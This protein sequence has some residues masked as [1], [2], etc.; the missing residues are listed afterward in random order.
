MPDIPDIVD[1][2][3]N[4]VKSFL[5]E[6]RTMI[7]GELVS[8]DSSNEIAQVKPS[9]VD[10]G[11]RGISVLVGVHLLFP[12][13]YW[14]PSADTPGIILFS[15]SDFSKWW[16][17]GDIGEPPLVLRHDLNGSVFIPGIRKKGDQRSYNGDDEMIVPGPAVRLG[18]SSAAQKIIK[19]DDYTTH[20]ETFLTALFVWVTAVTAAILA[21]GT[22]ITAESTT[23]QAALNVFKNGLSGDLSNVSKTE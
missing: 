15:E 1:V 7:P 9:V 3:T 19:G 18:S 11:G 8:F 21:N 4:F 2:Q 17:T 20:E 13:P 6:F 5:A 22:D 12:G 10:V 14:K 23:F 16:R